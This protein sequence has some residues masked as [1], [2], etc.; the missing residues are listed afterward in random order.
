MSTP[1]NTTRKMQL[2]S[3]ETQHIQHRGSL[4]L[5]VLNRKIPYLKRC[6]EPKF[7]PHMPWSHWQCESGSV[8]T[9]ISKSV[10][11][12][13]ETIKIGRDCHVRLIF[14]GPD[15]PKIG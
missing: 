6:T 11:P 7:T 3:I 10:T 12:N 1:M 5:L 13:F 4:I 14:G 15:N 9:K 8:N 2:Y